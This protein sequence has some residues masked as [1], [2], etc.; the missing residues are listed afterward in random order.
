[1]SASTVK[2]KLRRRH[3]KVRAGKV[4]S[5]AL[6]ATRMSLNSYLISVT[7]KFFDEL[8]FLNQTRTLNTTSQGPISE[9]EEPV[10]KQQRHK[11]TNKIPHKALSIQPANFKEVDSASSNSASSNSIANIKKPSGS[12]V[13]AIE[14]GK[15]LPSGSEIAS[16]VSGTAKRNT[17]VMDVRVPSWNVGSISDVNLSPPII[18][19]RLSKSQDPHSSSSSLSPWQSASQCGIMPSSA[20]QKRSSHETVSRFFAQ[21][22]LHQSGNPE[23]NVNDPLANSNSENRLLKVAEQALSSATKPELV[24]SQDHNHSVEHPLE[25]TLSE[26]AQQNTMLPNEGY[27]SL[28]K[29]G[30]DRLSESRDPCSSSSHSRVA[31]ASSL[32]QALLQ[33]E[34]DDKS[35]LHDHRLFV[36]EEHV[37][38]HLDIEEDSSHHYPI[39]NLGYEEEEEGQV[40]LLDPYNRQHP[41]LSDEDA[42]YGLDDAMFGDVDINPIPREDVVEY[43]GPDDVYGTTNFPTEIRLEDEDGEYHTPLFGY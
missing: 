28:G 19:E 2:A 27:P 24:T 4:C 12:E 34:A 42:V 7:A 32:E 10:V 14:R 13:W 33:Y 18:S 16:T 3:Q 37:D 36:Y 30:I 22:N 31:S 23:T 17:V 15:S 20:E 21:P 29:L 6:L 25:R 38:D 9:N 35:T 11:I 5:H 41:F 43:G 1:V 40:Y 39:L 8:E 26:I